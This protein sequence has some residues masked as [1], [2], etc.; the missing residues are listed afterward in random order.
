MEWGFDEDLLKDW[1]QDYSALSA[2]LESETEEPERQTLAERFVVPPFS[3]LDARQGYWQKRKQAWMALGIESELGRDASV[4][5]NGGNFKNSTASRVSSLQDRPS[6]FDPVLCELA[7]TWFTSQGAS[8]LDPFAGGSVRGIVAAV[9]GR[10]YTG[11]DLR[12]EQIAENIKQGAVIVPDN[13]PQWI[14][15]DS[16]VVDELLTPNVMFDFIFSCPPYVDLEVYSDNPKDIS[17]MSYEDFLI[18][19]REIIRLSVSRL[20]NDRFACFVAGEVRDKKGNYYNFVSDTIQAF[21][22]AGCEYYN[23]AILVT[24]L[25][26]V[27]MQTSR[28]FPIGR[29]L[30]KTHQN[31]L[32]FVKGDGRKAAEWCGHI[33]VWTPESSDP[34]ALYSEDTVNDG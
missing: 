3:V 25:G 20:C 4:S 32:V 1:G 24:P 26:T 6:T 33:D 13:Q 9:L 14:A 10:H 29:K 5:M 34:D 21:I 19:Y 30:G 8:V 31:V 11:I 2:M 7:Y 23:E 18:A 27:T 16:L 12:A 28:N 17:S 15:G 22:D